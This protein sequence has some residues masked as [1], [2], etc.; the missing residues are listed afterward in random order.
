MDESSSD[1]S[2][3]TC[4]YALAHFEIYEELR[5]MVYWCGSETA[6]R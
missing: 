3:S 1:V 2:E 4:N 6:R 5:R